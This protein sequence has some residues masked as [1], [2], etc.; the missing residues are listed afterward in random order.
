[1]LEG[2]HTLFGLFI[3]NKAFG[4]VGGGGMLRNYSIYVF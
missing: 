2:I 4:V 3:D 1:M